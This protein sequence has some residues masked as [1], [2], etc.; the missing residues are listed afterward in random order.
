MSNYQAEQNCLKD[1]IIVVTGAG[2]GIGAAVAKVYAQYGATVILLGRTQKKLEKIYD[3]IVEAGSPEPAIYPMELQTAMPV[4][5]QT[6]AQTIESEFGHLDGLLHNAAT[7][8]T[9][10]PIEHYDARLW[11]HIMQVNLN[12]TFFLTKYCL[13]LLNKKPDGSIIFTTANVGY[14]G[15]AYWG[16]YAAS[17]AAVTNL[18]EVLAEELEVNT[19]IRVNCVDPGPVRTRMNALAYPGQDPNEIPGPEDICNIYLYLMNE[20]SAGV[21]GERF[22]AQ[23]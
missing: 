8:G 20:A 7:L 14:K 4:E 2:D 10:T 12:A 5:Y 23:D 21:T 11:M 1:R 15:Q 9:L 3:E 6:L 16:A 22:A 13:P 17:K 18:A 19:S